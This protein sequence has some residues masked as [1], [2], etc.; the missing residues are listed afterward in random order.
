MTYPH[1]ILFDCDGTLVDSHHHIIAVMQKAFAD[2]GVSVPDDDA[3][4]GVIGMS[5]DMAMARLLP[6]I[7]AESRQ[8]IADTY[9]KLYRNMPG[10]Y[11]LHAGVVSTLMALQKRGYWLGVVTGKSSQGLER[12]FEEFDLSRFFTVW[13]TADQCPSKPH[14]GMTVACMEAL[15]VDAGRT[16]VVGDACVD[17]QMAVASGAHAIGVSFG[18]EAHSALMDAGA[19]N[20]VDRFDALMAYFPPLRQTATSSTIAP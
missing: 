17:M 11:G 16:T 2:C 5:L 13:R 3:I 6:D 14:P 7:D 8:R 4:A 1:L 12:M 15:G 20:I 18:V 19:E 10:N 9:R